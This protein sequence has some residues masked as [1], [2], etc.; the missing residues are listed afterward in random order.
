VAA[1][2]RFLGDPA[3]IGL[4]FFETRLCFF[5]GGFGARLDLVPIGVGGGAPDPL[6]GGHAPR[7]PE[8]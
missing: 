3:N 2:I 7:R 5:P 1:R 8:Q 4:G 6:I